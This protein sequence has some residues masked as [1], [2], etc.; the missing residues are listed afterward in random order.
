MTARP[1]PISRHLSLIYR[2]SQRYFSAR[3]REFPL[4][5]GQFPLLLQ[6]FR[7]PDVTQEQLS[8]RLALD[9]A[10]T[11]RAAAQL[12]AQGLIERRADPEDRR[13]YRLSP[14]ARAL[15]LEEQ[16]FSIAGDLQEVLFRGM[17]PTERQAAS[18]LVVR[19]AG[20]LSACLGEWHPGNCCGG[21]RL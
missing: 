11:A 19:M 9:K 3:L 21:R 18:D 17:T 8:Q 15:A 5:A 7:H 14:T 2:Y 13:A 16:L 20:N 10:T 1:V 12:L 4:E 6:L